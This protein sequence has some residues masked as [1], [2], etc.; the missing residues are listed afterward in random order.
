MSYDYWKLSDPYEET[1]ADYGWIHEDDLPD[2]DFVRYEL[3]NLVKAVYKTGNINDLEKSLE[4]ICESLE[5]NYPD[6]APAIAKQEQENA[7]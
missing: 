4:E 7:A 2:L 6:H 3:A 1:P 5:V